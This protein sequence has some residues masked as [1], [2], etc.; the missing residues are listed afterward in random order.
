MK[1][2]QAK[3]R[4][5]VDGALG[6][7]ALSKRTS[8]LNDAHRSEITYLSVDK[9]RPYR[10]QARTIFNEDELMALAKTIKEHGIR[11]PL[12]VLRVTNEDD[13]IV[14]EVISG[15]RRLRAAKL[16]DLL[17]VPCI[18]I[19][20]SQKAEEIALIEN[21]QRQDLHPVELARSL[22]LLTEHRGWG[23]Q[24]ELREKIGIPASS[25]SELLKLNDLTREIQE[26]ILA[27]NIRGREIYRKLFELRN[28]E[29]R[30]QFLSGVSQKFPKGENDRRLTMQ[31]ILRVA[32]DSSGIK[33]QKTKFAKLSVEERMLLKNALFGIIEELN[34]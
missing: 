6:R 22:K 12:T 8:V 2:E 1:L 19:D 10:N 7:S 28:D 15:E 20:D 14:F 4:E 26:M 30:I 9:L 32:L 11:Q 31:S 3:T 29:Q 24:N 33:V 17:K 16:A 21:I 34:C 5:I 13:D 25:L 23:S 18:I 27:K